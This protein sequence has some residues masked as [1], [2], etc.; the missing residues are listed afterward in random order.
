MW[1]IC[2]NECSG[3]ARNSITKYFGKTGHNL[4]PET[5]HR[6]ALPKHMQLC[7]NCFYWTKGT[8]GVYNHFHCIKFLRCLLHSVCKILIYLLVV[9][10]SGGLVDVN[11]NLIPV[12]DGA[13]IKKILPPDSI[14]CQ[15]SVRMLQQEQIEPGDQATWTTHSAQHLFKRVWSKG[16]L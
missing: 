12:K 1:H 13:Q 6:R 2:Q 3:L 8:T 16:T 10:I 9:R 4:P 15:G 7:T 5:V 11:P 14:H